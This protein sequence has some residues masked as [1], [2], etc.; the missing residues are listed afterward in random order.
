MERSAT[1]IKRFRIAKEKNEENGANS[2]KEDHE[3]F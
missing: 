2:M 1:K 3:S